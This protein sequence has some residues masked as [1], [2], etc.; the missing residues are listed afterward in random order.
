VS[1]SYGNA[2]QP[3]HKH[4]GDNWQRMSDK[5]L[6]EALLEKPAILDQLEKQEKV[7]IDLNP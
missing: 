3:G 2:S 1:L 7:R 4:N 5:K 6:R